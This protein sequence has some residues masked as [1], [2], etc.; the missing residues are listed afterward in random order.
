MGAM[1]RFKKETGK[2]VTEVTVN[3]FTDLCTYLWCCVSSASA[4]DKIEFNL[5][6][7]EFADALSPEDMTVWA[8][9]MQD[10]STNKGSAKV[11][12]KR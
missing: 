8:L 10:K 5:P 1:L 7:M 12:K 3:D 6:L 2:E 4:H 11:E 9:Q